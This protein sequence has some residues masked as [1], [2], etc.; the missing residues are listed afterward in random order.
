[1]GENAWSTERAKIA[2]DAEIDVAIRRARSEL[3]HTPSAIAVKY[4]AGYDIYIAS[5]HD[6]SQ[7]VLQREKLQ[8]LQNATKQQLSN[9]EIVSPDTG[10][11]STSLL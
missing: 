6:G 7:M 4:V 1:M 11:P 2:T 8:G 5:L 3:D 9:V 10:E